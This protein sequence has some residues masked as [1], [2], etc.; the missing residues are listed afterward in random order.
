MLPGLPAAQGLAKSLHLNT[1]CLPQGFL[2][3]PSA[4][5][6][7][8]FPK[9]VPSL[10]GRHHSYE[11]AP[12]SLSLS[13]HGATASMQAGPDTGQAL[14]TPGEQMRVKKPRRKAKKGRNR[15]GRTPGTEAGAV[16]CSLLQ[17]PAWGDPGKKVKKPDLGLSDS[18]H[19]TQ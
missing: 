19:K 1:L 16:S 7:A 13:P 6:A 15:L 11:E 12:K 2:A 14:N 3:L 18:T 8:S 4:V 9:R 5:P 10:P 17:P